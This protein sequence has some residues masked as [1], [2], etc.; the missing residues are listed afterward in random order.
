VR[1]WLDKYESSLGLDKVASID[2]EQVAGCFPPVPG[3]YALVVETA[4]PGPVLIGRTGKRGRM[5]VVPGFYVYT[6]SA[7]G[8]VRARQRCH[9]TPAR[10]LQIW[11]DVDVLRLRCSVVEVWFTVDPL[12]PNLDPKSALMERECAVARSVLTMPAATVPV[13]KFGASGCRRCPA[14]LAHFASRPSFRSFQA[15]MRRSAV[16][17]RVQRIVLG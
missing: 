7:G 11:W 4:A 3:T 13:R 12:D 14:H 10:D 6:G 9:L 17:C 8:G 5:E 1:A 2:W 16:P 15:R